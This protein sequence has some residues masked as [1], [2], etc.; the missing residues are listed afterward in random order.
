MAHAEPELVAID[1]D[2]TLLDPVGHIPARSRRAIRS[3]RAAGIAVILASGRSPWS[4]RDACEE[5][6]LDGLQIAMQGGL[7]ASPLRGTVGWSWTLSESDVREHLAFARGLGLTPLVCFP[8]GFRAEHLPPQTEAAAWPLVEEARHVHLVDS[9]YTWAGHGAIRTFL[10]TPPERHAEVRDAA[11]RRFGLRYEVT[12]GDEHGVELLAAGAGKGTAL[13]VVAGAFGIPGERVAAIGDGPNDLTML[14]MAGVSA[15]MGS[16]PPDVRAAET[17]VVPS[18]RE[19]GA[20]EALR[21]LFPSV[22]GG[23]T[24]ALGGPLPPRAVRVAA[25]SGTMTL[26]PESAV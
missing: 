12:W 21:R 18:N 1:M 10:S 6:E 15:A 13:S 26:A 24:T 19:E 14:R 9:L 8:D 4:M 2:G 7:I 3:L 20:Y 17:F 23:A 5:L 11:R 22:L 25:A 16:A